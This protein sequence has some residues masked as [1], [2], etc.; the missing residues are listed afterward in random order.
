[1]KKIKLKLN[2]VGLRGHPKGATILVNSNDPYWRRRLAECKGTDH[3]EILSD[4]EEKPK[5][6]S[7]KSKSNKQES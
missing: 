6:I 7:A 4:K 5:G 1:M 3:I 2:K